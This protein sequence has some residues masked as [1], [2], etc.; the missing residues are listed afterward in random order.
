MAEYESRQEE[1]REPEEKE[2]LDVE[3]DENAANLVESFMATKDGKGALKE[4]AATVAGNFDEAWEATTDY[5]K[6]MSDDW[7]IFTGAL[8]EKDFPYKGAANCHV[9]IMLENTTRICFR[10]FAE[11]FGDW[12]NVCG[13]SPLG[14][15]DE[16]MAQLVALHANWQIRQQI[17]D[18]KRQMFRG[19]LMFFV[20]GDVTCHSWYDGD[21]GTNRHEF[22]TADEFVVPYNYIDTSPNYQNSFYRVRILPKQKHE[23]EKMRGVW[24]DVDRVIDRK[25][26]SWDDDPE[27]ELMRDAAEAKGIE[28]TDSSAP[29]KLLWYEGWLELP[30][31]DTERFCK[32]ILDKTTKAI[33]ELTIYEYPNWQDQARFDAQ[34]KELDEYRSQKAFHDQ[35]VQEQ[36][37]A[38][39][40]MAEQ[41]GELAPEMAPDQAAVAQ[42]NLQDAQQIHMTLEPPMPPTWMVDPENPAELPPPVKKDPVHLFTHFVLIEP[43]VGNL[44]L[45]YGTMQADFN[46]A[47]NTAMNQAVDAATMGNCGVLIKSDRIRFSEKGNTEIRPGA[48]LTA[49]GTAG[50]DLKE[51]IM[52]LKFDGANPQMFEIVDKMV[53]YGSSSMQ[54]PSVLSGD[55]GKSGETFR[56]I[57]A[58][59]E[60]ATKQTSVSTR[61][62]GD[63]LEW[64]LKANAFLNSI[65]MQDEEIFH[66]AAAANPQQAAAMQAQNPGQTG[67]SRI[68][69]EMKIGRRLY[70]RNYHFEI[71]ADLRFVTQSQRIQEADELLNIWMGVPAL[72]NNLPLLWQ[73]MAGVFRSRGR[74]DLVAYL[75]SAPPPPPLII[76][77]P[78]PPPLPGAP[79]MGQQQNGNPNQQP[80]PNPQPGIPGPKPAV[81]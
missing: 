55:P 75:G 24:Y 64:V 13:V 5:R 53:Q 73:I 10:A 67:P 76:G 68:T 57:A 18:F 58:R 3:Y 62:F 6:N 26:P 31:Q 7:A 1:E 40:S 81:M 30:N 32:V 38:I 65:H 37:T 36:A 15:G 79:Q 59:I 43:I 70:E 46:R 34:S 14:A 60:Q 27:Q 9:P 12:D 42:G 56:G 72:A 54:A 77:N 63:G 28:T 23:L 29:Y 19:M 74:E 11:L 50:E 35:Q 47:A 61:K 66:V 49:E 41:V 25:R 2:E 16:E 69:K 45:G 51:N 21:R 80:K 48:I 33:L 71:R 17:P 78:P 39:Q 22:M 4:I 52:P 44:G 20:H 8:P